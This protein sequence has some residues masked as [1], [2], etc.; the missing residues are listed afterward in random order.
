M[1]L[2]VARLLRQFDCGSVL[3][4]SAGAFA[5]HKDFENVRV[6]LDINSDVGG[7]ELR[8]RLK[9]AN[10]AVVYMS[11]NDSPGFRAAALQSGCLAYLTKPFSAASLVLKT[12]VAPT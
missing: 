4:T 10:I 11:G 3:F 9:A 8:D 7:L 1:L 6:L 12:V 2:S 5:I